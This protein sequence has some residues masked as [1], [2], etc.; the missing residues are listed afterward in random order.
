MSSQFSRYEHMTTVYKSGVE[1]QSYT[2]RVVYV[3][4][5]LWSV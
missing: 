2:I 3:R 4:V 1:I 5:F